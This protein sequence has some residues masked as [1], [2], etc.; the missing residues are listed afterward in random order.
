M[1]SAKQVLQNIT[2]LNEAY[3]KFKW[4]SRKVSYGNENPDKTFFVI[5]RATCKVGLFSYVMTNMGQVEYA[6]RKGYIP[7]IDMQNNKN[8]YLTDEQVGKI[9]AWEFFFRQPGGYSLE[10]IKKSKNIILNNAII[11][12]QN[13][14]PTEVITRD[15]EDLKRWHKVFAQYLKVNE[16]IE[17]DINE[18][19]DTMFEGKRVLGVLSRGTD[20]ISVRPKNHP[21]QPD[22]GEMIIKVQDVAEEKSCDYIYMA[23]EDEAVY[24]EFKKAFGNRLKTTKARRVSQT[25]TK[26]INDVLNGE[27]EDLFR[28]GKEY[29]GNILLLAKCNCLVA[30]SAG[31]TYGALLMSKGYEYRYIYDLGVY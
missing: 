31:G 5:R 15:E 8:T 11:S 12:E 19:Y 25:G 13:E 17:K 27:A 30:G 9:N 29:L 3:T 23:T 6:I 18:Q 26:N 7:V 10:D 4:R 14:Y 21:V 22:V 24:Q 20:Y 2:W 16:D 1:K 28:Q